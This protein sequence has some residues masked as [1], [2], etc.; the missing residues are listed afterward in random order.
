MGIFDQ[1]AKFTGETV[2]IKRNE[3]KEQNLDP[4]T[5]Q[6]KFLKSKNN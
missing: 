4:Q 3:N 6:H 1:L 2:R 5:K